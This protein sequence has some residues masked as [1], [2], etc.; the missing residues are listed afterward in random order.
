MDWPL[1]CRKHRTIEIRDRDVY[2][3]WDKV[4]VITHQEIRVFPEAY[5]VL[6]EF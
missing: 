2:K 1:E 6:E 4:F 3:K 5:C